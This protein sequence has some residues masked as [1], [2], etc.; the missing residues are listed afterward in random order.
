MY[1]EGVEMR[2]LQQLRIEHGLTQRDIAKVFNISQAT[3]NNWEQGK[4]EP[5][6]AKLLDISKYFRVSI[7]YLLENNY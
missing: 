6:I 5:C 2:R 7:D 4:T 1:K 3:Y